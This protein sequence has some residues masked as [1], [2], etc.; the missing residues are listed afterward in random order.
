MNP[1][2]INADNT[3][4]LE[5]SD[6]L[7]YDLL[8]D[9]YTKPLNGTEF[10]RR[11]QNIVKELHSRY[12]EDYNTESSKGIHEI[13]YKT[14]KNYDPALAENFTS[15]LTNIFNSLSTGAGVQT[16]ETKG[17]QNASEEG[18]KRDFLYNAFKSATVVR[19]QTVNEFRD[20]IF[21][22]L[23]VDLENE[24]FTKNVIFL[25]KNIRNHQQK[26][27]DIVR[28][29]LLN[30]VKDNSSDKVFLDKAKLY[31]STGNYTGQFNKQFRNIAETWL[32][33]TSSENLIQ[34]YSNPSK[35]GEK[36]QAYKAYFTL[37][38]YDNLLRDQWGDTIHIVRKSD[39]FQKQKYRLDPSKA[40]HGRKS[41]NDTEITPQQA[42]ND[43]TK[44]FI[45]SMPMYRYSING[46]NKI[47]SRR[48][49][50]RIDEAA[51]AAIHE[52]RVEG[53][54]LEYVQTV[55][56]QNYLMQ[57]GI[58]TYE[59]L[60]AAIPT[61]AAV[62]SKIQM[63]IICGQNGL[64]HRNMVPWNSETKNAV[65]S[66]Y[67][68]VFADRNSLYSIYKK[69]HN[70]VNLYMYYISS[71]LF[72]KPRTYTETVQD[73]D[74]KDIKVVKVNNKRG[75]IAS[76]ELGRSLNAKLGYTTPVNYNT[77]ASN[78]K[79]E[80]KGKDNNRQFIIN[81][82][83]STGRGVQVKVDLTAENSE[84]QLPNNFGKYKEQ[85]WKFCETVL[86]IKMLEGQNLSQYATAFVEL[87]PSENEALQDLT[88]LASNAYVNSYFTNVV[89]PQHIGSSTL[90]SKA[91]I[92]KAKEK[93]FSKNSKLVGKLIKGTADIN[94]IGS[95][96]YNTLTQLA[97]AIDIVSGTSVKSVVS[98]AEGSDI[99]KYGL[100]TLL[101]TMATRLHTRT[102]LTDD[103]PL[104]YLSILRK[105]GMMDDILLERNADVAGI[106]KANKRWSPSEDFMQSFLYE[107]LA[108]LNQ[109]QNPSFYVADISDKIQRPSVSTD[110]NLDVFKMS[111][112][113]LKQTINSEFGQAFK[114]SIANINTDYL[115]LNEFIRNNADKY[116]EK[117][118]L[119][120]FLNNDG[121]YRSEPIF[122][123]YDNF[124]KLNEVLG[125]KVFDFFSEVTRDYN[126]SNPTKVINFTERAH[127]MKGKD[128]MSGKTVFRANKLLFTQ[129]TR[130]AGKDTN[131]D[132]FWKAIGSRPIDSESFWEI[133]KRELIDDLLRTN[134]ELNLEGDGQ[135]QKAL[136]VLA[137]NTEWVKDGNLVLAKLTDKSTGEVIKITR[138]SDLVDSKGNFI[139][140]T[141]SGNKQVNY[142]SS[143][144]DITH[145]DYNKYSIE[146]HPEIEKFN[147]L[148]TL[149]T[150]N[151]MLSSVGSAVF[152]DTK[153][154]SWH[155]NELLEEGAAV[156]AQN[157]RNVII[158][159]TLKKFIQNS[160]MGIIDTYNV[161]L[162]R[163][164]KSFIYTIDGTET[165]C[166]PYD[167]ATFV[168]AFV[169]YL[170]NNSLEGDGVGHVKKPI[171]Q[172]LDG[173]TLNDVFLK[174]ASFPLTN[175][176]ILQSEFNL[177]MMRKMSDHVWRDANG[178]VLDNLDITQ[179]YM[180]IT[181]DKGKLIK[182]HISNTSFFRK[183]GQV[184]K[185]VA[186]E[187]LNNT[188]NLY[189]RYLENQKDGQESY[190]IVHIQSN[191]E[192]WQAYGG[193]Y[194]VEKAA[195][196]TWKTS[197][198]S[199]INVVDHMVKVCL[200]RTDVQTYS[201]K[202]LTQSDLFQPL[203]HAGIHYV[204]TEGAMKNGAMN[205]NEVD[206]YTNNKDYNFG[207]MS[208]HHLGPQL[209][210]QHDADAAEVS[211]M[212]Q[213]MSA[214]ASRGFTGN[215][216][217]DAYQALGDLTTN[218]IKSIL[219]QSFYIN[220]PD[221]SESDRQ[222][223][224]NQLSVDIA[225]SILSE[226]SSGN[227]TDVTGHIIRNLLEKVESRKTLTIEDIRNGLPYS[228]GSILN[229]LQ[230]TVSSSIN[231]TAIKLKFFGGLD[232]LN[233]SQ[234]IMKT[235]A[236]R[237]LSDFKSFNDIR[238]AQQE[239]DTKPIIYR[240][241]LELGKTYSFNGEVVTL[242][243]P[244]DYWKYEAQFFDNKG[245]LKDKS[246]VIR[247]IIYT[248]SDVS[249]VELGK[250]YS[251]VENGILKTEVINSKWDF[252]HDIEYEHEGQVVRDLGF[253]N[254][255]DQ[256]II[257]D[258]KQIT[259]YGKE[260]GAYNIKFK[261]VDGSRFSIWD[262]HTVKQKY[263]I[264]EQIKKLEG[265]LENVDN[266]S[267]EIQKLR[268]IVNSA[269]NKNIP[270]YQV[271][272]E[273]SVE[274]Q[275]AEITA[276]INQGK[277]A[278]R[279]LQKQ[280]QN[281]LFCLSKQ[282]STPKVLIDGKYTQK[283]T[284]KIDSNLDVQVDISSISH[285]MYE[286]VMPMSF[287]TIFGLELNDSLYEIANDKTFFVKRSLQNLK[288]ELDGNLFDVQ[289]YRSSGDH[290]YLVDAARFDL[291]RFKGFTQVDLKKSKEKNKLYRVEE[292]TNE[293][294][295][296]LANEQDT[297]YVDANGREI[298]V[299]NDINHYILNTDHFGINLSPSLKGVANINETYFNNTKYTVKNVISGNIHSARK[300]LYELLQ[301]GVTKEG[302]KELK[303]KSPDMY[304]LYKQGIE[305]H[306]SFMKSLEV[307]AARIPS[308]SQQSFMAMKVVGFTGQNLNNAYVS[309]WQIFLQGSDYDIDKVTL[310][311]SCFGKNGKYVKWSPF[312]RMESI[313]QLHK[314]EELP[315]PNGK[316]STTLTK[317]EY[318]EAN[319]RS[320]LEPVMTEYKKDLSS[321]LSRIAKGSKINYADVEGIADVL[322]TVNK[323]SEK[324]HSIV[325][326]DKQLEY[327]Q[328]SNILPELGKVQSS[329]VEKIVNEHNKF[330]N[331]KSF[332]TEEALKNFLVSRTMSVSK[333]AANVLEAQT[334]VDAVTQPLRDRADK[335]QFG[336][337]DARNGVGNY[338][339]KVLA[340]YTNMQGKDGIAITASQGMK[341]FYAL[342]AYYNYIL[343]NRPDKA[344]SLLFK[345]IT[346]GDTQERLLRNAWI[347]DPEK[348][349]FAQEENLRAVAEALKM[350][351]E[352]VENVA[353]I[354]SG[355]MTLA[356]DNAKE[357][358]LSKL[359]A[360]PETLGM[361]LYGI[362]RG[363]SFNEIADVLTSDT[364]KVVGDLMKSNVFTKESGLSFRKVFEFLEDPRDI[365]SSYDRSVKKV[366]GFVGKEYINKGQKDDA[367]IKSLKWSYSN[368]VEKIF[369]HNAV[370]G[371]ERIDVSPKVLKQMIFEAYGLHI[372]NIR[373]KSKRRHAHQKINQFFEAMIVM[374][375][376]NSKLEKGQA[377]NL[378]KLKEL[379][380]GANELK[381][382]SNM[383]GLNMGLKVK[384]E[385][386]FKFLTEFKELIKERVLELG[387]TPN[388]KDDLDLEQFV[389][390]AEY[391]NEKINRYNKIKHTFPILDALW[392]V[393]QYR[394]YLK[395][396]YVDIVESKKS[397]V[398]REMY[399]NY[400]KIVKH[401][402][403][404]SAK[405]RNDAIKRMNRY[406][407]T[408]LID[409]WLLSRGELFKLPKGAKIYKNDRNSPEI[410][411]EMDGY[412][413]LGTNE[414]NESFVEWMHTEVIPN[415]K[416]GIFVSGGTDVL[417]I[418]NEFIENLE[419]VR[420]TYNVG[421][422]ESVQYTLRGD[423][424]E[425][426]Q[427]SINLLNKYESE[428]SKLRTFKYT[429][430]KKTNEGYMLSD[431]F[432][433][434]NFI[435]HKNMTTKDSLTKVLRGTFKDNF[436]LFASYKKFVATMDD[437]GKLLP[438]TK[439][440][441]SEDLIK[442]M[443]PEISE[444]DVILNR[445]RYP[446]A[447]VWDSEAL[448][449]RWLKLKD[450]KA[451]GEQ[452]IYDEDA[453]ALSSQYDMD[454]TSTEAGQKDTLSDYL[455][456]S[457]RSKYDELGRPINV[458]QRLFINSIPGTAQKV[459]DQLNL[460]V[461]YVLS[462]KALPTQEGNIV[463]DSKG[464]IQE[465]STISKDQLNAYKKANNI[466]N[467]K[468]PKQH[469]L[470]MFNGSD[471]EMVHMDKLHT[472]L[473]MIKENC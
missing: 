26:L 20:E 174:T 335:S 263:V 99:S 436:E 43:I 66:I 3:A 46:G 273:M 377:T 31:D 160:L 146:L 262:L 111:V 430:N 463:L 4:V 471:I 358:K 316:K 301:K 115:I 170:E 137:K 188:Y 176:N 122:D 192:L 343:E 117:Y 199:I 406:L 233:P 15:E 446:Y 165:D 280:L 98:T 75:D 95:S 440:M 364:A 404:V 248:A 417:P 379:Y 357:L 194:C 9:H 287:K 101:D 161:A 305:M 409:Q 346:L 86:Q 391:R 218:E 326:A 307:V 467:I 272:Y 110:R 22:A 219:D 331:A 118:G 325:E 133:R 423:L 359:N 371:N 113:Q 42:L 336:R 89:I 241:Q 337:K 261:S 100:T 450:K 36:L 279:I 455:R 155:P 141:A 428:F 225:Q 38:N 107:Y 1:C 247:E 243:G 200:P 27:F 90:R 148:D 212:T 48:M 195:N 7:V 274:A 466:N 433:Y 145:L 338:F 311:N 470:D 329:V 156:N 34:W 418:K 147:L 59:Q 50:T 397:A 245:N 271:P 91:A 30:N 341:T 309:K 72:T 179:G 296:Q 187:K 444:L 284:V 453:Y 217:Y 259:L 97:K 53:N 251:Y 8:S 256:G 169:N 5:A 372:D 246:T 220:N 32:A 240:N 226:M 17:L 295:E 250:M 105:S 142:L 70:D 81:I 282:N 67:K 191:Y 143:D 366:L 52:L 78:Y 186:L 28:N 21:K 139:T 223:K 119:N 415:I 173:R 167:G 239:L 68:S 203:K 213:V 266:L 431:L 276:A 44:R 35:Y 134:C 196:G 345:N 369:Q 237:M 380:Y 96:T 216:A 39:K 260:L 392:T 454:Y 441:L 65:Y 120:E 390:N 13:L 84:F 389:L 469:G 400:F 121:K 385:D 342:S 402:G 370:E 350:N 378:Q 462:K 443:A 456:N 267:E 23:V 19:D 204:V 451:E 290:L 302:L 62:L 278:L 386:K 175:H 416:K 25:N 54:L 55:D 292:H 424:S 202:L 128:A 353:L 229:F 238:F 439:N 61:D 77:L 340:K 448:R 197:E 2:L 16:T 472:L 69:S 108:P 319:S 14:L 327:L 63:E 58:S 294:I 426:N 425:R 452:E 468:L 344:E 132:R 320:L 252:E 189:K 87:Y 182:I 210:A 11:L 411:L 164:L 314:S 172:T 368:A 29:Y 383:L 88:Y 93:M 412:V 151:F 136:Q 163:D 18:P 334:S 275:K 373:S 221:I 144:F 413:Q 198:Q 299:T 73:M 12:N 125:K 94:I 127:Y 388:V 224:I 339:S 457:D 215:L 465:I 181:D 347:K 80:L 277:Q 356:T 323:Y 348:Y 288:T 318:L 230:S 395:A 208:T 355:V 116:N 401:Y 205:I 421:K 289:I 317:S 102:V 222:S 322:N 300:F 360:G 40:V 249:N 193:Q 129:A 255:V 159:A 304:R 399:D 427:D 123:V 185:V 321:K 76:K 257:T 293:I 286:L 162:V 432:T 414:G 211:L 37:K 291:D 384:L 393:P 365:I 85:F 461:A 140:H 429:I 6:Q 459:N 405:D 47:K 437:S 381:R 285:D 71:M 297:V 244:R 206:F 214:L 104:H 171:G 253:K 408:E 308:Q 92:E 178:K 458:N 442:A 235:Y 447:V 306:T 228:D 265:D 315:Y 422:V 82:P 227:K 438:E 333:D 154:F 10:S 24:T 234:G 135:H 303:A 183:N 283:Q 207:K 362:I 281:D 41:W 258:V 60:K 313:E 114:Q 201:G 354:L 184:Y 112:T 330:L 312:F 130:Y 332:K 367:K 152:H 363:M 396:L 361:Y 126:L 420:N 190:D 49:D 410:V 376:E 109:E 231:K 351:Y 124:S 407:Q 138:L 374:D 298:I 177:N 157:K 403:Y 106:V 434:Y 324:I 209:D 464:N 232:V 150:Q 153:K 56:L 180:H 269:T 268:N 57:K 349:D 242:E 149:V 387:K 310:M 33:D 382:Y 375:N 168:D 131:L 473:K 270:P 74:T 236:G 254:K 352:D 51:K 328:D 445:K 166:K 83:I 264:S 394:S 45:E 435:V 419:P 460:S 64:M 103:S 398:F 449:Y 79:A 158:T